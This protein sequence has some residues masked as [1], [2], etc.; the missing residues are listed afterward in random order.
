MVG[1]LML[2]PF[3]P[4]ETA[5]LRKA[6]MSEDWDFQADSLVF[7]FVDW[8]SLP[9]VEMV[10]YLP[11]FPRRAFPHDVGFSS[12]YLPPRVFHWKLVH[13]VFCPEPPFSE[14]SRKIICLIL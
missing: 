2:G 10:M 5:P 14:R 8:L 3:P 7:L 6:V 11:F 4:F 1:F 12:C 13:L 9:A